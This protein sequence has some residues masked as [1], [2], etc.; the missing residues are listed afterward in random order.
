MDI[1]KIFGTTLALALLTACTASDP[2]APATAS[3]AQKPE[4]W[5]PVVYDPNSETQPTN[6]VTEFFH[7]FMLNTHAQQKDTYEKTEEFDLRL[8]QPE[9]YGV[10]SPDAIYPIKQN[11]S[12]GLSY[13]A[14][15]EAYQF[16]A[17][18]NRPYCGFDFFQLVDGDVQCLI[19]YERDNSLGSSS[20]Y[21]ITRL[22]STAL[23]KTEHAYQLASD[24]PYPRDQAKEAGRPPIVSYLVKLETPVLLTGFDPV[25]DQVSRVKWPKKGI[26]ADLIGYVCTHPKTD[27][28]IYR[29]EY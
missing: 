28:V 17:D 16:Y 9:M 1:T 12:E 10:F 6:E 26:V 11:L 29:H 23:Q 18:D 15:E 3:E 5:T 19:G 2:A 7:H 22:P 24:C 8:L 27:Q 4:P 21:I 20:H 14:D 13:N 25:D